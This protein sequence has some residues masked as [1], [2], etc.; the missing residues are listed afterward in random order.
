MLDLSYKPE[1]N[2][3]YIYLIDLL[4]YFHDKFDFL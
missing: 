1:I 4:L 2:V 3:Y